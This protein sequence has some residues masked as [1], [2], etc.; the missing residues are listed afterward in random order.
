MSEAAFYQRLRA[1][2]GPRLWLQRIENRMVPGMADVLI[3]KRNGASAWAELKFFRKAN[4]NLQIGREGLRKAQAPWLAK[5]SGFGVETWILLAAG[6][7]PS[8]FAASRG[9]D[10]HSFNFKTAAELA[11]ESPFKTIPEFANYLLEVL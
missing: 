1:A 6:H 2:A 11:S 10:A 8:L 9:C 4:L 7:H 5:M 3:T